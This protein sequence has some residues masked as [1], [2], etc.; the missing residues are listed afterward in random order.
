[1]FLT[2]FIFGATLTYLICLEEQ[3]LPLEGKIGIALAAG[4]L[5]GLITMLVQQIGLFSSGLIF[6]VLLGTG[7]LIIIEQF[8]HPTTKW[9]AI[10]IIFGSGILF[11]VL[12]LYLQKTMT[13]LGTSIFGAALMVFALDYYIEMFML[14]YYIWDRLKVVESEAICWFSWL[15]LGLWPTAFVVG[16]V[17]QA[18]VTGKDYN[19]QDGSGMYNVVS[20][21]IFFIFLMMYIYID[22]L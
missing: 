2:G 11:A 5:C 9:I 20:K 3:M 7:A 17:T 16:V 13:I 19:H 4:L 22:T 10:G 1:M 21:I 18:K 15:L 12:G 6:G 8:Y 14:V